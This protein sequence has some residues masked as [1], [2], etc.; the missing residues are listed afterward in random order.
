MM[1]QKGKEK[2]KTEG[3][4][5]R[6]KKGKAKISILYSTYKVGWDGGMWDLE[7]FWV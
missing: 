3:Q 4:K 7:W 6:S 5:G 2:E 1:I